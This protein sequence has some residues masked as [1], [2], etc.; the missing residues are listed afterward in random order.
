MPDEIADALRY[1][2]VEP[3]AEAVALIHKIN[4]WHRGQV[5]AGHDVDYLRNLCGIPAAGPS[6]S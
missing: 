5:L 3:T 4:G 6:S 2:G 1:F